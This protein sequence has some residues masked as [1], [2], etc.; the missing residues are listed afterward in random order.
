M[1]GSF[2]NSRW[3]PWGSCWVPL[4]LAGSCWGPA[5][6][7]LGPAGSR[8][9]FFSSRKDSTVTTNLIQRSDDNHSAHSR[10]PTPGSTTATTRH[11]KTKHTMR[12]ISRVRVTTANTM[13]LHG[14]KTLTQPLQCCANAL[15]CAKPFLLYKQNLQIRESGVCKSGDRAHQHH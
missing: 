10:L 15:A 12:P 13:A 8:K 11:G 2:K 4:G 3:L 9:A 6:A 5:G 14:Q 7:L 1:D